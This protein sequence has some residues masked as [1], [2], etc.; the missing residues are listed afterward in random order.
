MVRV[1]QLAAQLC[2]LIVRPEA[3]AELRPVGVHAPAEAAGRFVDLRV[4]TLVLERQ[5]A[6]QPCD[7]AADDRDPRRGR[8]A[9]RARERSGPGHRHRGPD[10]AGSPQEIAARIR[11]LALAQLLDFDAERLRA[12]VLARE[13]LQRAHQR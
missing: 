12:G 13:P 2:L 9:R 1:D 3:V 5:R 7:A 10:G 4:D 11:R 8:A 6:G